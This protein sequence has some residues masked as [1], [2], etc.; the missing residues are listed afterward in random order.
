ML[1][2]L[3]RKNLCKALEIQI[4]GSS[5]TY[6]VFSDKSLQKKP[7]GGVLEKRCSE[8]MQQI[9]RRTPMPKYNLNH[10]STWVSSGKFA[11]YF[12]N[13]FFSEHLFTLFSDHLFLG[14]PVGGCFC[15]LLTWFRLLQQKDI[16]ISWTTWNFSLI[17]RMQQIWL[18]SMLSPF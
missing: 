8:N 5:N 15:R 13:T 11:A 6:E 12:Q 18:G 10:I 16:L 4:Q 2:K 17:N 7:P 1:I 9:C 3:R 14:T